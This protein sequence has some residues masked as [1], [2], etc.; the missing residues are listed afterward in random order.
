MRCQYIITDTFTKKLRKCKNNYKW[1][2]QDCKYCTLHFN[3]IY[4]NNTI[5]IQ[6]IFRGYR[7]RKIVKYYSN[8]PEEIQI[9]IIK[10][11]RNDIII[12]NYNKNIVNVIINKID[13]FMTKYSRNWPTSNYLWSAI[14][15]YARTTE[16]RHI[17]FYDIGKELFHIYYLLDKYYSILQNNKSLYEIRYKDEYNIYIKNQSMFSKLNCLANRIIYNAV[18]EKNLRGLSQIDNFT[19]NLQYIKNFVELYKLHNIKIYVIP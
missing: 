17:N 1:D 18:P 8:C 14:E 12:K 19:N 15:W 2:I 5:Y 3:L 10:N 11:I 13:I 16:N 4:R 6:K 7:Y 9:K